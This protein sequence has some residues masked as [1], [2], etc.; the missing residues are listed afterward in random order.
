M[1]SMSDLFHILCLW[2]CE[3]ILLFFFFISLWL[4][5]VMFFFVF[6]VSFLILFLMHTHVHMQVCKYIGT[7][8]RMV[9]VSKCTHFELRFSF[10]S[11][12]CKRKKKKKEVDYESID[13]ENRQRKCGWKY[14]FL[15]FSLFSPSSLLSE[16]VY[17]VK[18]HFEIKN[19]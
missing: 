9:Q 18:V 16:V 1:H 13:W 5:K 6:L 3:T 8:E 17:Y 15:F 12:T 4:Y 7:G 11:V 2:K 14:I 10:L 19:K